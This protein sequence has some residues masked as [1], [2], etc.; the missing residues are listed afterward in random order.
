MN[1][2]NIFQD[3][4]AIKDVVIEAGIAIFKYIHHAPCITS[5]ATRYNMLSRKA[6]AGV[7]KL[8]TLPPTEGTDANPGLDASAEHV[9]GPQ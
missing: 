1:T 3:V 6:M 4:Q 2:W 8:E 5:G 9:L 7:I